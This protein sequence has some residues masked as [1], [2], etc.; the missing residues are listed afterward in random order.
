MTRVKVRRLASNPHRVKRRVARYRPAAKRRAS[1]GHR[2]RTNPKRHKRTLS[3]KQIKF[4]GTAAQRAG[5]KRRRAKARKTVA[6][7]RKRHKRRVTANPVRR[8]RRVVAAAAPKRR[9]RRVSANPVRK[10]RTARRAAAPRRRHRRSSNPA[11]VL[12]LGSVNPRKGVRKM[13]RRKRHTVARRRRSNPTRIVVRARSRRNGRRRH[14]RRNPG[15]GSSINMITSIGGGLLGVTVAKAA[16]GFLPASMQ[17]PVMRILAAVGA[18]YAG[19]MLAHKMRQPALGDALLF[20][21]LMQAGSTALNAWLPSI[22]GQIGLNGLG[23]LLPGAFT[24]PQNPMRYQQALI[25]PQ[26]V[27]MAAPAPRVGVNGIARAF[28]SAF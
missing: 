17:S 1:T 20:G 14:A 8:R 28:G 2:R 11:L 22:G 10:R 24:I 27:P 9:K 16:P 7:P 23:E 12:T 19:K 18:G 26:P 13:K 6:A 3:A 25:G 4:F 21:S 15:M 5:L